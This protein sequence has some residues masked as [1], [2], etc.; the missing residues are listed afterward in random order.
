MP[1]GK[2]HGLRAMTTED[3]GAEVIAS[4]PLFSA[5]DHGLGRIEGWEVTNSGRTPGFDWPNCLTRH[6]G[7]Q[8]MEKRTGILEGA[9]EM[10]DIGNSI[11]NLVGRALYS[12]T[13]CRVR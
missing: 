4:D 5:V 8:A 10:V 9:M 1:T 2:R 11:C 6:G 7:G 13:A 3:S 12:P